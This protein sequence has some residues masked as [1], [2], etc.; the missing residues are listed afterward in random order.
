MVSRAESDCQ[1]MNSYHAGQ[2]ST[3][4]W[5]P[6]LPRAPMKLFDWLDD[7]AQL[8]SQI[9]SAL[10]LARSTQYPV[11]VH[12]AEYLRPFVS[13]LEIHLPYLAR[14][15]GVT[16]EIDKM[17]RDP[18]SDFGEFIRLQSSSPEC[19]NL[20]LS[21]FLL[22]PVQRLMKYPLFFKVSVR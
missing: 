10:Q 22:K 16:E 18:E 19:E 14:L 5:I 9:S 8:H 20:G 3:G 12:L 17:A 1:N 11:V 13:R 6:G 4:K 7:I 15:E 2:G 21:S